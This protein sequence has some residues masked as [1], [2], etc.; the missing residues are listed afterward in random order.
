MQHMRARATAAAAGA[1][2]FYAPAVDKPNVPGLDKAAFRDMQ[3]EPNLTTTKK[4]PGMLAVHVGQRVKLTVAL[5]PPLLVPEAVGTVVGIDLHAC[6]PDIY[7]QPSALAEGCVVLRFM[8]RA[9][10]VHFDDFEHAILPA[11][12]FLGAV[13]PSGGAPKPAEVQIGVVSVTPQGRSWAHAPKGQPQTDRPRTIQ[14]H[15]TQIPLVPAKVNTLHGLQGITAEP[16]LIADWRMPSRLSASQR[17]LAHYVMLSR[18]RRI[19]DLLSVGLPDRSV[20]EA[21]PPADLTESLDTLFA[22][23]LASTLEAVARERA[24]LHW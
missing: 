15:R 10:H 6:E 9:I 13:A 4:L 19:D 12:A 24:F 21:G 2:L 8:P 7:S 20:L 17:W 23:K 11:P 14:V 18:P 1:L 22:A 16:G 5:L 3:Q